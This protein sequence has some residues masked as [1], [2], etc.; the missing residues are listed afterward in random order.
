MKTKCPNCGYIATNHEMVEKNKLKPREGDISFC[1]NCGAVNKFV[2]SRLSG[3]FR[4]ITIL[5]EK[6]PME[7]RKEIIKIRRAWRQ[8]RV[9]RTG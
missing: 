8:S 3:D 4:L 6:L 9:Y 1:I 5:E 7:T 2:K